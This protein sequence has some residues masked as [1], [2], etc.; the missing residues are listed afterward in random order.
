MRGLSLD[1]AGETPHVAFTGVVVVG[2]VV[3][4]VVAAEVES[5]MHY[6]VT[7]ELLSRSNDI[8]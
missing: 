5:R 1:V 7:C 2:V 8:S 4:G 6:A 3:V